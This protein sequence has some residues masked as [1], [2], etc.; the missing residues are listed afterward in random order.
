MT[1]DFTGRTAVVTGGASGM[2]L[3]VARELHAR[4]ANVVLA[5]RRAAEGE[6]AAST[7]GDRALFVRTDVR[8]ESD[9]RALFETAEG[10]F[11]SVD[12]LFNNAGIE[13]PLA[14]LDA[15]TDEAIDDV[16]ATNVKGVMLCMKHAVPRMAARG[17]GVIVNNASFVGT[18]VP[19]PL[20]A[21]YGA[22]KAAVL[23]V[24]QAAAAGY[25][26]QGV[27]IFTVCP[28]I[29][30][31]PMIDRL[32]GHQ[33]EAKTQFGTMNPSGSIASPEDIAHAV[34]SFFAEP[35]RDNGSAWLIDRGGTTTRV[36][37]PAA[38]AA[39]AST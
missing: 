35:T 31:T 10:R 23:S 19:F 24:T 15:C 32:T 5:A 2:G 4:G 39:Q 25:G 29:T 14:P 18:V 28:W 16:L 20:G 12:L 3:A 36:N 1:Q 22:S 21:V 38:A 9:V 27:R 30:D 6:A 7:L 33:P 34:L 26:E 13:G 8:K 11:G 17:G 37:P